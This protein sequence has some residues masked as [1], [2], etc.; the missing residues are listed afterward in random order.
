MSAT[1]P[2][3]LSRFHEAGAPPQFRIPVSPL[4]DPCFIK[5]TT[6]PV[7]AYVAAR[8]LGATGS[9]IYDYSQGRHVSVSGTVT[10][11]RVNVYDYDQGC[12]FG[13]NGHHGRFS[14]YHYGDGHHVDLK[15][16]DG[17]KFD[18]YDYGSSAHFDGKVTNGGRSVSLYDYG[19][20][21]HYS[22]S[23]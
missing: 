16:K 9:S 11:Q 8:L 20:G 18:G 5:D 21:H 23:V 22:F 19:S 10:D 6:R 13:G 2:V 1:F 15:L 17:G 7:V 3:D 14:L 12:H 4:R